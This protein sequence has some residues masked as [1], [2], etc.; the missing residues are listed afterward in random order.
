MSKRRL[1]DPM[2]PAD[3]YTWLL[4]FYSVPSKPVSKR[5]KIW[6]KLAKAGAVQLK[7]SVYILPESEDHYEF[8]E[9]LISEVT[10]MGGDGAFA[11]V[12]QIETLKQS[13]I[14]ALFNHQ[15]EQEYRGVERELEYFE[16]KINSIRKG[17]RSQQADKLLEQLNKYVKEFEEIRKV[18]FFSAKAGV[19]L[20]KRIGAVMS[21]IKYMTPSSQQEQSVVPLIK[22]ADL[23]DYQGKVWVTR[24]NPFVDRMASAWLIK[25]FI[26]K[27]AAFTFIDDQEPTSAGDR[28]VTFDMR[29]G[30]FTHKGDLCTFEVLIKTFGIKDTVVKKIVEIVHELDVKD[31]R[32]DNPETPGVE[33]VLSGI[34]KTAKNDAE[35]LER[36]MAVFEMLYAAKS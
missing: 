1:A 13:E 8:F 34:R 14:V 31:G 24:K 16:R 29:G 30:E 23:D 7:G 33:E 32:Y 10:S 18:D 25:K 36:G 19:A 21:E 27:R 22:H 6:R 12:A 11:K 26:D 3:Q 5:M 35:A 17:G 4:I 2:S 9:W 15:R 20:G 28:G